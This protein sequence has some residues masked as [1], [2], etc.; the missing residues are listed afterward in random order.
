MWKGKQNLAAVEEQAGET[1][2]GKEE[3]GRKSERGKGEKLDFGCN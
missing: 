2:K 1:E 3:R